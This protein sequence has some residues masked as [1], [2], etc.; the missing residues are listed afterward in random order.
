MPAL[1]YPSLMTPDREASLRGACEHI[2]AL[3]K[4]SAEIAK[5]VNLP[6][7]EI[8]NRGLHRKALPKGAS[9]RNSGV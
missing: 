4:N 8:V 2:W 6:E 1:V 5:L 3:G 9:A 7:H